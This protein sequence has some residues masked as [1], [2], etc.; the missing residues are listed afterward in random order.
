MPEE[1]MKKDIYDNVLLMFA[2][3]YEEAKK[4]KSNQEFWHYTSGTA[5]LK[6][7]DDYVNNLRNYDVA[8][9]DHCSFLASNIRYMNDSQ[10]FEIGRNIYKKKTGKGKF[11]R[12]R[13]QQHA[14]ERY[15]SD[16]ILW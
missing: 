2:D 16:F 6:I 15:I 5:I 10:E 3:L 8:Y 13:S 11:G 1:Q 12:R 9:V 7:F 4:E 14:D